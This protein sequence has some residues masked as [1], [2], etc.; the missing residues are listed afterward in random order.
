MCRSQQAS[1]LGT[2]PRWLRVLRHVLPA[3]LVSWCCEIVL[4]HLLSCSNL[5][6]MRPQWPQRP[7]H[8]DCERKDAMGRGLA[9]MPALRMTISMSAPWMPYSA[10]LLGRLTL[11]L[12]LQ[13]LQSSMQQPA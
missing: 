13:P 8:A 11:L 6:R 7:Q 10:W 9:P 4:S 1:A 12:P 2:Q 3:C 5:R